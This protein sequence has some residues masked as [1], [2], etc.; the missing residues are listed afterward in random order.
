MTPALRAAPFHAADDALCALGQDADAMARLLKLLS[1]P[2]R[3]RM[4]CGMGLRGNPGARPTVSELVRLTGLS[5][6]RVS[7]HLALL[8]ESG[9]V[10]AERDG[11]QMRYQLADPHMR[12]LLETLSALCE[13]GLSQ[14]ASDP[15]RAR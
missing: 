10:S 6:S 4:L 1:N 15:D 7:Q 5:Q 11:Q 2:D 13:Q 8:R 14:L 3:L 12:R 9:M